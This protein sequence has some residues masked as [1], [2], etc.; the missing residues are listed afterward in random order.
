[1]MTEQIDPSEIIE[2][3]ECAIGRDE[4]SSCLRKDEERV[5]K[6][7]A[8]EMK[9]IDGGIDMRK[10]LGDVLDKSDFKD[11][12]SLLDFILRQ[13]I[14][15]PMEKEVLR[16]REMAFKP[17]GPA[18]NNVMMDSFLLIRL[19]MQLQ[20]NFGHIEFGGVLTYDF[21]IN[22][23]TSLYGDP[24]EVYK[25]Q[26]EKKWTKLQF[27]LNTD[28]RMGV[29]RHW[30]AMVVNMTEHQIQYADSF[31]DPPLSG[32]LKSDRRYTGVTDSEGHFLTFLRD[33]MSEVKCDFISHGVPMSTVYTDLSV[34]STKDEINCGVYAILT[35]VLNAKGVEFKVANSQHV[36]TSKI[37][38]VRGLL[39]EKI[40]NYKPTH[41]LITPTL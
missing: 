7:I 15:T 6:T 16:I 34:Q 17:D 28:H 11:V 5:V 41:P 26:V 21:M 29:G 23:T 8:K 9:L 30:V 13:S 33:W 39:F 14:G 22:P 2:S 32:L 25:S 40:P 18:D 36:T 38:E 4:S 19:G 24:K 35:L 10:S 20:E 27:I 12:K 1:M 31:G 3:G 37:R